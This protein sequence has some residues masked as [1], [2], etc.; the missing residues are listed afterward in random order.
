M[1]KSGIHPIGCRID[2]PRQIHLERG[3]SRQR[4]GYVLCATTSANEVTGKGKRVA[5][6]KSVKFLRLEDG[7][8]VFEI[9]SGNYVFKSRMQ[10]HTQ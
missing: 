5:Q 8:A 7:R 4:Q 1:R 2:H 3:H 6:S 9:E 10:R